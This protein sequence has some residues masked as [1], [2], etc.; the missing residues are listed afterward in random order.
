MLARFTGGGNATVQLDCGV[1]PKFALGQGTIGMVG[2]SMAGVPAKS[3]ERAAG[4]AFIS[5]FSPGNSQDEYNR[6]MHARGAE[7]RLRKVS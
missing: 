2:S 7:E 1:S 3:R 4:G 5:G 6:S